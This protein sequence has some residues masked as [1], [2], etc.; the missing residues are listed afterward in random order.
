[1]DVERIVA[2]AD[3]ALAGG[4]GLAEAFDFA[5]GLV[6]VESGGDELL[7]LVDQLLLVKVRLVQ[8]NLLLA[9]RHHHLRQD[10]GDGLLSPSPSPH[11]HD[12]SNY[13]N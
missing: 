4:R 13:Q 7:A 2:A 10:F 3:Y 8:F 5:V 12:V 1:M 9:L 6:G 11:S